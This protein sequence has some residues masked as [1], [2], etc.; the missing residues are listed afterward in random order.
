VTDADRAAF[1]AYNATQP[2]NTTKR[3]VVAK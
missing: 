1:A 2:T 3:A